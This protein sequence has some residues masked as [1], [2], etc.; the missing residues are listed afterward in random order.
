MKPNNKEFAIIKIPSDVEVPNICSKVLS[1]NIS[2]LINVILSKAEYKLLSIDE[3][4]FS[5]I[6]L[7]VSI[8]ACVIS[9]VFSK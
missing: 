3:N 4:N 1:V 2:V 9:V 8:I 6:E 5:N 7:I